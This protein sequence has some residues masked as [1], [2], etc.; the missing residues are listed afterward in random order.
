[1]AA[2]PR[3]NPDATF[4]AA[5]KPLAHDAVTSD[6]AC[7]LGPNHNAV[8]P[9]T[10]LLAR[11]PK[12]GPSLVWEVNKGSGYSAPAVLGNR[13]VLLHRV[14]GDEVVDCLKSDTGQRCWR[15]TYPSNYMDRY[16]YCDGP[17]QSR[18]RPREERG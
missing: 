18:H 1:M 11:F 14:E 13:L 15:F 9:E 12:G 3:A 5:P 8:S 7:F 17:R 6:W 10:R 2:E 4:H 16:G